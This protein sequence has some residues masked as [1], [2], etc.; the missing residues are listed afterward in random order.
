MTAGQPERPILSVALQTLPPDW[1]ELPGLR[2][3]ILMI[4]NDLRYRQFNSP[5]KVLGEIAQACSALTLVRLYYNVE[6][7]DAYGVMAIVVGLVMMGHDVE[8]NP[9]TM[10]QRATLKVTEMMKFWVE[11]IQRQ[12]PS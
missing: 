2:K 9:S 12:L 5:D 10:G 1:N 8:L 7:V 4:A 3:Y 6:E 11:Y